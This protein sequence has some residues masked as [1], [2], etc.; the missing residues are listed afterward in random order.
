[1]S[2]IEE[3]KA[4]IPIIG[5]I[6]CKDSCGTYL[7]KDDVVA[8]ISDFEQALAEE[9]AMRMSH[10]AHIEKLEKQ[11]AEAQEEAANGKA[12]VEAMGKIK[13]ANSNAKLSRTADR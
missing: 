4:Y 9:G 10:E 8:L 5:M 2:K 1:M 13:H 7:E 3:L 6:E 11:L 12:A